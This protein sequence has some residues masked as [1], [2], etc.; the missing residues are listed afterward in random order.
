LAAPGHFRPIEDFA[1]GTRVLAAGKDLDWRESEVVFSDGTSGNH[2]QPYTVFVEYGEDRSLVV[3]ADHLFLLTSGRLK[4][5]DRLSVEDELVGPTGDAVAVL[6][7]RIGNFTG[8]FHHIV[9]TTLKVPG[10]NLDG[11][12][13]NTNG[14]VTA[15]YILQLFYRSNELDTGLLAVEQDELPVVGTAEYAQR[16][17]ERAYASAAAAAAVEVGNGRFAPAE[18]CRVHI[19]EHAVGFIS[20]RQA[21]KLANA[22]KRGFSDPLSQQ[23]TEY[24]VELYRAFYPDVIYQIDWYNDTVNA[25]AW[26][27][28]GQ[29]YVALLGGLIR[30]AALEL[31][32]IGLVLAHELGHHYGGPPAYPGGLSCEGQ[33]DFYGANIVMRRVWFGES[34]VTTM[35]AAI[36][37]L[38][39]FFG[40]L[41]F[42]A[43]DPMQRAAFVPTG[44]EEEELGGL[45]GG[46]THP[47]APCRIETY[48]AALD[49]KPKPACAG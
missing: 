28:N 25:Y 4:R 45:E 42:F 35:I 40:F 39:N 47:P 26:V 38:K 19:P 34:Y 49:L 30:S 36:A 22:P 5:A 13:L 20:E 17:G 37:Q 12:L 14:V 48:N 1:V 7:V 31:E 41:G 23:W 24:L 16:H 29:R 3:T 33:A 9:A 8:G 32:G 15:D 18:L 2:E 46:C 21:E 10:E 27:D 44:R 43:A 11:H 6:S